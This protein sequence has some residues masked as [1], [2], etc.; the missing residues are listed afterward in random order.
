M[1]YLAMG[2]L[3]A[4]VMP[5]NLYL[6]SSTIQT[7]RSD[8][9]E[10]GKR[11]TLRFARADTFIAL[12]FAFLV[13]AAIFVTTV[14]VFHQNGYDKVAGIQD[15]YHLMAPLLGTS[16]ASLLLGVAL[17]AS[18]QS[19]TL[20][21][22]LAGQVVMEG[23]TQFKLPAWGRRLLTRSIAVVPAL[24]ITAT[25]GESGL[26]RLLIL[27]QVVLSLQLPFAVIP[28]IQLTSDKTLMGPFTISRW[29][30]C[31][32]WTVAATVSSLSLGLLLLIFKAS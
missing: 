18:G 11:E 25:A 1:L 13:N 5:H 17:L 6:H 4:T 31:L 23:Y 24:F 10:A 7:R 21:A 28:L 8:V 14:T 20:T 30:R 26:A 9:T 15:A 2:I 16:V 3:G 32:A 12:T 27:S 29:T 22:T 19:S